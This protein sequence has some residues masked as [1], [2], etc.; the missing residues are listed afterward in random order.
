MDVKPIVLSELRP[1]LN[2]TLV[3][4]RIGLQAVEDFFSRVSVFGF[5]TETNVTKSFYHRKLR[6]IQVGDKNEQYI[7]DL[8]AFAGSPARL[9]QQGGHQVP[10]W[11]RELVLTLSKGLESWSHTKVGTNLQFDYEVCKWSLGVRPRQL[12]DCL[13]AEKVIHCGA[14]HF[15]AK[16]FW[17]LD[18]MVCRY[19]KLQ[20]DKDLQKSFDLETPLTDEQIAYAAL[21]V[22]LPLAVMN[23]QNK[24]L[25]KDGLRRTVEIENGAIMAFG[26][27]H[28]RG[29]KLDREKWSIEV[30]KVQEQHRLNI[31][32]LDKHFIPIVGN[33]DR[34]NIDVEALEKLWSSEKDKEI[35][36]VR[37]EEY[38]EGRRTITAWKKACEKYEGQ[39]AISYS[40]PK[41]LLKVL[42]EQGFKISN[43]D[44]TTLERFSEKKIID[45]I[46]EYRTTQ[47]LLDN[48]GLEFLE[49]IDPD[50]DRVHGKFNQL[51]AKTG[52]TSCVEPTL[53]IIP[54]ET[55]KL[56]M[57]SAFVAPPGFKII[58][59]DYDGCELRIMAD[60]SKEKVWIDAFNAGKDVHSVSTEMM[61]GEKWRA[62]AEPGCAYYE[63][64][65]KC[66]CAIHQTMR[67]GSKSV[68]F[69]L[70]YGAEAANIA[71]Q[72]KISRNDA[73]E[74]IN[75]HKKAL[76]VLHNY[77]KKSGDMAKM[78]GEARTAAGRRCLFMKPD[79]K[80]TQQKLVQE[81]I[82][83]GK[84]P[85]TVTSKEVS[86]KYYSQWSV[87]ERVGKNAPVQGGNADMAKSAMGLCWA[88]LEDIYQ[89]GFVSLIHDE[90]V[91]EVVEENAVACDAFLASKMA[92]AG[93]EF[94]K[95]VQM[96]SD[97]HIADCWKK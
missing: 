82:E 7:I 18:D 68:S 27:M 77:L 43:T 85:N 46:R 34:P 74:L 96:T 89:A 65:A 79:Y 17:A 61:E 38:R 28:L 44:D 51:A 49:F 13:L 92:E 66:E 63:K 14:V 84:D 57:R 47:K 11:A 29:I 8:L 5:D 32:E 67:Q 40:A 41:Q 21:D 71:G 90:F 19:C 25:D 6:T 59:R 52:R 4:D 23:A 37:L 31:E 36:K 2:P 58:T 62:A 20:I 22:R 75:R 24:I 83:K 69:G 42:Q 81:Y 56:K 12:Y 73:Q 94:F 80:A 53:Q 93:A 35:R 60:E 26:D 87:I 50:T 72:L 86:R 16:N 39:A 45:A 10:L 64:F 33:K 30:G 3:T 55:K 1:A 70:A 48:Y 97:G 91:L 88:D 95:S 76:P 9:L 54:K 15:F 78:K